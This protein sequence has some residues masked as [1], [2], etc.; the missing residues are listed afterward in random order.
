[1]TAVGVRMHTFA[2]APPPTIHPNPPPALAP[3]S[4]SR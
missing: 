3:R 4:T 1:V 2:R